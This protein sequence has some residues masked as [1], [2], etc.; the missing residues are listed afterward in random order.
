VLLIQV[1]QNN[2]ETFLIVL[3]LVLIGQRILSIIEIIQ[4]ILHLLALNLS[5][6][7]FP[8]LISITSK[9]SLELDK[10]NKPFIVDK[11]FIIIL[12]SSFTIVAIDSALSKLCN[13]D[14]REFKLVGLVKSL[15]KVTLEELE[16]EV[17][18]E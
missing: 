6:K 18:L 17:E 9:F 10:R 13:S 2:I 16:L 1:V 14:L 7:K 5:F 12:R 11:P 8:Y 3:E 15:L 4:K